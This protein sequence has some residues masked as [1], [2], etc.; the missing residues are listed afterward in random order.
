MGAF[1]NRPPALLV[2][3]GAPA[4]NFLQ[5]HRERLFPGVPMLVT[6]WTSAASRM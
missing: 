4:M 1:A 6:P 2:P 3:F 5:R